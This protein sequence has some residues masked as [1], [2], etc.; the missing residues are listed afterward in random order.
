MSHQNGA[1]DFTGENNRNQMDGKYG[2]RGNTKSWGSGWDMM[3]YGKQ[4]AYKEDGI[5]A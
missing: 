2:K 1:Q 5:W 3:E 4:R